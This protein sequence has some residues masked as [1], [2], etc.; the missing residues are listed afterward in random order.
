M[1]DDVHLLAGNSEW[2]QTLFDLINRCLEAGNK[3]VFS[4]L[5]PADQL[6]L[7]L[8]DLVSR[9][10]WGQKWALKSLSD[11]QRKAMLFLRSKARAIPMTDELANYIVLRCQ[12][13]NASIMNCLERLDR[14]SLTEKRKLTI[15]FVKQ[16]MSW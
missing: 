15:P 4:A 6:A 13:D 8:P 1:I 11:E 12:Q 16:V 5:K 7:S 10:N 3:M 14:E 2:Q 9:L